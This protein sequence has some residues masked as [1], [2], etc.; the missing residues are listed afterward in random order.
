MW[1]LNFGIKDVFCD[2]DF[3]PSTIWRCVDKVIFVFHITS[4]PIHSKAGSC[5]QQTPE[6][7]INRAG[8][9]SALRLS[10]EKKATCFNFMFFPSSLSFPLLSS[11]LSLVFIRYHCSH[12]ICYMPQL[13]VWF[14]CICAIL[15]MIV[16]RIELLSDNLM[17]TVEEEFGWYWS[18]LS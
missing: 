8:Y 11:R 10:I 13:C 14:W 15:T 5:C 6:I 1:G 9:R 2:K 7:K 17:L 3:C 16:F 12:F 18:K 4:R